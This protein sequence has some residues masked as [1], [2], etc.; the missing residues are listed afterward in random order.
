M[1]LSKTSIAL[2]VIQLLLVGSIAA[3]Y[4]Y[5]RHACPR[6]WTR[7]AAIDPSL[8]MRGRYLSLRLTVDGC[9]STLPS[10]KLAVFLRNADGTVKPGSPYSILYHQRI[11]FPAHLRVENDHL[12]ALRPDGEENTAGTQM[13][14][15]SPDA[16]CDD[17]VLDE[18]VSFFIADR[19]ASPLPL[20]PGQELWIEVTVPPIGPPR[21]LQL[22]VKTNN[23][24]KPLDLR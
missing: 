2:L 19:A 20:M 21:P 9:R 1:K 8:P 13:I 23:Q 17:M 6:V 11:R 16:A 7:A 14:A 5:Q 22:A 24:W 12:I 3:K 15:T 10:A 18:P 4:M